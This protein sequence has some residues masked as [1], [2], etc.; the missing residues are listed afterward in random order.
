MYYIWVMKRGDVRVQLME[1]CKEYSAK[2]LEQEVRREEILRVRT[3]YIF[4]WLTLLV[5][6]FNIAIPI[7]VKETNINTQT[8]FFIKGYIVVT[9]LVVFAMALIIYIQLPK[10]IKVFPKASDILKKIQN[11]PEKYESEVSC[12]YQKLLTDDAIINTMSNINDRCAK[13]LCVTNFLLF[14]IVVGMT[15]FFSYIILGG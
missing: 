5:A 15:L 2:R 10:K 9:I 1:Y 3:D 4:K 11:E 14:L 12:E 7:I 6:I 13:I 8:A